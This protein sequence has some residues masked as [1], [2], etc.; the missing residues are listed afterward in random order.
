MAIKKK[1]SAG[2]DIDWYLISIDRLKQIGLI[3]FLLLVA[4]AGY[5]L[6]H[7]E[8]S[9]PRGNAE[10]AIAD[11]RQ[12]LNSLAASKDFPNRRNE[13]ERAQKKL[14]EA[15]SLFN[16]AKYI[17]AQTAALES[18]T[19]SRAAVSGGDVSNGDAQFITV[20][21]EV[22]FQKASSGDWHRAEMR[23]PLFNGDWVKTGD[24]ASAELVFNSN[25]SLYTI[26]PNALLEIY[27][28]V[29]PGSS[30]KNSAVQ[31]TVGTVE[32]A[33]ND[34]ASAVRTPG[35]Q[36][37]IESESSTQVGV[38]ATKSTSVLS[39]KGSA[40]VTPATGGETVK[41]SSGEKVNAS[42]EGG[43]SPV[44]K[45]A[46]PP[47]LKVPADNQVFQVTA[48]SKVDFQWEPQ[49]DAKGYVL[50]VSRARLFST[51]EINSKRQKTNASARVT[52][53]GAFYWRV[54]SVGADGEA[55]P[56]SPFRRF[57][58]SGGGN[59]SASGVNAHD[60]TPPA[61]QLKRPQPIGGAYFIIEGTTE[62]GST[63]FVNDEEVDVES[64]GHFK[65]LI[66]F[67]KVGPNAVIVKAVD[68]AGN[69]T[70]QSQS[71][72]VEE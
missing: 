19:I 62:A 16:S 1:A 13:F 11:A 48:D 26:G 33:T 44:K 57:R 2:G 10:S 72:I 3:V 7:N 51:L 63:V 37:V 31:M 14:D 66:V 4:G 45:L 68:P 46:L 65:K 61:L 58:V 67:S 64:N 18:Q 15:N 55:G 17:D 43:L 34:Q 30:K 42:S 40:S 52:A 23:V 53:E 36:I 22:Q 29:Q 25:G 21:G 35:T 5:L 54:A 41:V 32:V 6:V 49:P 9:N 70:V 71:V 47:A 56:F 28:A 39:T 8:K 27:A 12:A 24:N 50:Q 69:Q 20:E 59:Q 38:D 60:S